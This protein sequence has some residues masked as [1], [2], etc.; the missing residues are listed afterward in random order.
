MS[1]MHILFQP[2][3]GDTASLRLIRCIQAGLEAMAFGIAAR[4]TRRQLAGLDR[5]ALADIGV[6]LSGPRNLASRP[7]WDTAGHGW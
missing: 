4:E 5:R 6:P 1:S 3:L 2:R 7:A